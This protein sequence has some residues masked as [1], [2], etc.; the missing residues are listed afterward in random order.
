M[1]VFIRPRAEADMLEARNWYD[2]QRSG[3]GNEFLNEVASALRQIEADP[4]RP[5]IYYRGL[6]RVLTRRF[7]YKVFYLVEEN[8]VIVFRVLHGFQDHPR[9]LRDEK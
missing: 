3:L 2:R 9:W 1:T 4:L 6:R 7:P 8:R 5:L